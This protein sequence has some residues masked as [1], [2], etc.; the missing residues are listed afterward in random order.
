MP[1]S[2]VGDHLVQHATGLSGDA[3]DAFGRSA[4]NRYYYAAYL[5]VREF[6]VELE[7]HLAR[8]SHVQIPTLFTKTV[9]KRLREE[10]R[11]QALSGMLTH[12]KR[13]EIGRSVNRAASVIA[14]VM[15][16][17]YA[18]R[19]A[20]DYHPETRIEG[21]SGAFRLASQSA[22]QAKDWKRNIDMAKGT[23]FDVYRTLALV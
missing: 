5:S 8:Q 7:P 14:D 20:A 11:R 13:D 2:Q 23:L 17:A 18:V 21:Q 9:P 6:L 12:T 19:V 1:M 3:A 15:T 10:A 16:V 4:F 22:A